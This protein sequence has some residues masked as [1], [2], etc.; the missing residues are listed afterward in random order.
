MTVTDPNPIVRRTVANGNLPD[1][2]HFSLSLASYEL[3][4]ITLHRHSRPPAQPALQRKKCL[5]PCLWSSFPKTRTTHIPLLSSM[6]LKCTIITAK[7][8]LTAGEI[9]R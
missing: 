7:D 4:I 9:S 6:Y 8:G 2:G 1:V 5:Q 3:I